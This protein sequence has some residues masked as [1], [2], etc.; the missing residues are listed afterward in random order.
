MTLI[1]ILAWLGT[2]TFAATGALVAVQKKFDMVGI[3][4][5][6]GV[7]GVGGGSIRDWIV[8]QPPAVFHNEA[9]M[10]AILLVALLVFRFY[11]NVERLETPLYFLDTFG[12]ALFAALGAN[13]GFDVHLGLLGSV[14]AGTV[15][16]VGGGVL[17]DVLSSQVPA[18]FYRNR[19]LYATGAATGALVVF[20]INQRLGSSSPTSLIAGV[21]TVML[22]RFASRWLGLR[23]PT[24]EKHY[25][26]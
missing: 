8:G 11:R 26:Y 10:W 2:L 20:L 16:G 21:L 7:T 19:D 15:S 22:I 1:D 9:Q 17:R 25:P 24:P 18:V 5:L 12:L 4:V 23:L 14:F 3:V 6:A 13:R